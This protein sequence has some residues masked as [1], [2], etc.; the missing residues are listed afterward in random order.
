MK[1]DYEKKL[2]AEIERRLK[3][4]PELPAPLALAGRV[5][6]MIDARASMVWY[7][8]PWP[9]WPLLPRTALFVLLASA[10]AG[11]CYLADNFQARHINLPLG[12]RAQQ[13][14]TFLGSLRPSF[15]GW[16]SQV[17]S[18]YLIGFG[19]AVGLSYL[20]IIGL[21]ATLFRIAWAMPELRKYETQ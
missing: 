18:S 19:V 10:F 15:L 13:T 4:L 11:V 8:Q 17:N 2:E 21:G 14:I 3:E 16:V 20:L 1:P 5:M 12:S 9:Q 6:A 7:R